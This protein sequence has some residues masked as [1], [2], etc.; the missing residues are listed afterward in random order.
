[1][2]SSYRF[3]P[4]IRCYLAFLAECTLKLAVFVRI[5]YVM[6]Y[7]FDFLSVITYIL[8]LYARTGKFSG[9]VGSFAEIFFPKSVSGMEAKLLIIKKK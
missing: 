5:L 7:I 2:S 3:L 6:T 4:V 1:M 9:K 8:G